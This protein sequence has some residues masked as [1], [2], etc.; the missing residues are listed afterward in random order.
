M[1]FMFLIWRRAS[2]LK[3]VVQHRWARP[4]V[5]YTS[6]FKLSFSLKTFASPHGAIRLPP[7]DGPPAEIFNED[8]DLD[9]GDAQLADRPVVRLGEPKTQGNPALS[10]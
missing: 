8:E 2:T 4:C 10:T 5:F 3:S 9:A 1:F 6:R 7:E